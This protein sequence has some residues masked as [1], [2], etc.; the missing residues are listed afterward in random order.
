MCVSF[1]CISK[2]SETGEG[3]SFF[4]CIVYLFVTG[5]FAMK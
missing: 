5:R 3:A 1:K 2:D 4:V